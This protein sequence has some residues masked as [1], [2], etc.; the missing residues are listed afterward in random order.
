LRLLHYKS[1]HKNGE[2][3]EIISKNF[4]LA[5]DGMI[6]PKSELEKTIASFFVNEVNN[7]DNHAKCR[8]IARYEWLSSKL[9]FNQIDFPNIKCKSFIKW[10]GKNQIINLK[11]VFVSS[12][13]ENPGSLFGHLLLRI[14]AKEGIFS[15]L[16]LNT[17]LNYG[18]IVPHNENPFAYI[19]NGIFGNYKSQFSDERFHMFDNMYGEKELRDMWEYNLNLSDDQK[20][21]IVYHAWEL[22]H[23]VQFDYYFFKENCAYRIAELIDM[24]WEN[25]KILNKNKLW[26]SPIEVLLKLSKTKINDKPIL[27]EEPELLMSRLTKLNH[28]IK[29][30]SKHEKYIINHLY[31]DYKYIDNANYKEL[32]DNKKSLILDVYFDYIQIYPK[33][34]DKENESKKYKLLNHR[35]KLPKSKKIKYPVLTSPTNG[36]GPHRVKF[37]FFKNKIN[38]LE[39][40][41]AFRLS[42]HDFLDSDHGHITDSTLKTFDIEL[43]SNENIINLDKVVFVEMIKLPSNKTGLDMD[44]SY[45]WSFVFEWRDKDLECDTCKILHLNY[46]LGSSFYFNRNLAY[47]LIKVFFDIPELH[48][49][50]ITLGLKPTLGVILKPIPKLK[51]N[52]QYMIEEKLFGKNKSLEEHKLSNIFYYKKD[53]DFRL[54]YKK[55]KSNEYG[56]NVN[57]F[58]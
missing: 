37:G 54:F 22:I 6:N 57:Y 16:M 26:S 21:R 1:T 27:Y 7:H 52:Y 50:K 9:N 5:E 11:L 46:G 13:L 44:D 43:I 29:Y 55:Q 34:K 8:F 49:K 23:G 41:L 51:L 53:L 12:Y 28:R 3:S 45:S 24:G 25:N 39:G 38:N 58:W 48:T 15:P 47:V 40:I 17:T 56:L 4:F 18:A 30:V 42:Y 36:H 10:I 33:T 32:N 19:Y 2:G 14:D 31:N 20:K 35:S